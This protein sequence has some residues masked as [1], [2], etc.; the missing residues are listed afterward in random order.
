MSGIWD[1]S[2]LGGTSEVRKKEMV[3]GKERKTKTLKPSFSR[4][5]ELTGFVMWRHLWAAEAAAAAV[6]AARSRL[7]VGAWAS[8]CHRTDW[9][10]RCLA[11]AG[12][13]VLIVLRSSRLYAALCANSWFHPQKFSK[14]SWGLWTGSEKVVDGLITAKVNSWPVSQNSQKD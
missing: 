1:I 5:V 7:G 12:D 8:P 6:A 2:E 9:R 13:L 3:R 11:P 14:Q 4:S 10:P